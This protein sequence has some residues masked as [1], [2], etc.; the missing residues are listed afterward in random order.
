M[1]GMPD[2]VTHTQIEERNG[3]EQEE[4]STARVTSIQLPSESSNKSS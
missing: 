2:E 4:G 3:A 1:A